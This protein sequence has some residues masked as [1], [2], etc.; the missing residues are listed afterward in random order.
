M[1]MGGEGSILVHIAKFSNPKVTKIFSVQL[2][3]GG[4]EVA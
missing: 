3:V 4:E 1:E 2:C